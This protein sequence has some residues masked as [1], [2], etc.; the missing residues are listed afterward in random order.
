MI[1]SKHVY[2]QIGLYLQIFLGTLTISILGQFIYMYNYKLFSVYVFLRLRFIGYK[3]YVIYFSSVFDQD[4]DALCQ[5]ESCV[6]HITAQ[7]IDQNDFIEVTRH[8]KMNETK[9]NSPDFNF[10]MEVETFRFGHRDVA[11]KCHYGKSFIYIKYTIFVN[12]FYRKR[13]LL[14]RS[15]V[16]LNI[17]HIQCAILTFMNFYCIVRILLS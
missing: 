9:M 14:I 1:H 3:I 6:L 11:G 15:Y 12:S 10:Y 16:E 4:D 2:R 8:F 5:E 17:I 13:N 7:D